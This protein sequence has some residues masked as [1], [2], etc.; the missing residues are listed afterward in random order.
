MVECCPSR[1][2]QANCGGVGDRVARCWLGEFS[3]SRPASATGPTTV[4]Q[5]ARTSPAR[6]MPL[7]AHKTR[8]HQ[9]GGADT[10]SHAFVRHLRTATILPELGLPLRSLTADPVRRRPSASWPFSG[11]TGLSHEVSTFPLGCSFFRFAAAG[12]APGET[13][14][15]L[16]LRGRLGATRR[17]GIFRVRKQL[18]R[19]VVQLAPRGWLRLGRRFRDRLLDGRATGPKRPLEP[20][21]FLVLIG[22]RLRF[23]LR[24]CRRWQKD[25][26]WTAKG[27]PP[28]HDFR[29]TPKQ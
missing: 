24:L 21:R 19:T 16:V 13:A 7:A 14:R 9:S 11:S 8:C 15:A 5:P 29:Q 10:R 27:L 1:R 3:F 4:Q 26:A 25:S 2:R 12:R 18:F 6:G 17:E 23:R 28:S 22:H 20:A